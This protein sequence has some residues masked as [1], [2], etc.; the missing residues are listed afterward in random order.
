MGTR[1][2]L[3]PD[4][5]KGLDMLSPEYTELH[6]RAPD[7]GANLA[8]LYGSGAYPPLTLLAY[9]A[10]NFTDRRH[11]ERMAGGVPNVELVAVESGD[12]NV[13]DPLIRRGDFLRLLLRLFMA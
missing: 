6:L 7:Y 11:A 10:R 2:D 9:S 1:T 3:S 13:V 5:L 4:F 12:H 8:E